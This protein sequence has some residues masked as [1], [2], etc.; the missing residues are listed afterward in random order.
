[1]PGR[2][3]LFTDDNLVGD[4]RYAKELFARMVPL[5]KWWLAQMSIDCADDPE[6][7]RL[8][9]QA[10]C[11]GVF[12]GFET[13]SRATLQSQTKG[14]NIH[15]DYRRVIS[16]LHRY[17]IAVAAGTMFGFDGD[18][19]EVFEQTV[20]YFLKAGLDCIQVDPV[21]PFPGTELHAQLHN[22]GRILT[23]DLEKFNIGE[24]VFAPR[25]MTAAE[26]EAG[27]W[28]VRRRFYALPQVA[29][30][31]IRLLLQRPAAGLVFGA[32]NWGYHR[33]LRQRIGYPP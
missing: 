27:L 6:L 11:L 30:R 19:P 7:L 20:Q 33:H 12:I 17:G 21:T 4:R 10:G 14:H 25:G 23:T 26:L 3:V 9:S 2:K 8:A 13:L 16:T 32:I 22:E 18:T 15:R 29:K 31:T 24:T 5:R 28:T 1:M